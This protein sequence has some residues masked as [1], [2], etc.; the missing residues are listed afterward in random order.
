MV[1]AEREAWKHK[2]PGLAGGVMQVEGHE[3]ESGASAETL[4]EQWCGLQ[5]QAQGTSWTSIMHIFA[6]PLETLLLAKLGRQQAPGSVPLS[7][8]S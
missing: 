2:G 7:S 5:S 4:E 6:L 3:A 1:P 8:S